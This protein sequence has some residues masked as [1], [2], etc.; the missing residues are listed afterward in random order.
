MDPQRMVSR[1][2]FVGPREHK[3]LAR[4][5]VRMAVLICVRFAWDLIGMTIARTDLP[6]AGAASG[7]LRT[8]RRLR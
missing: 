4:N 1:F 5:R 6:R 2:V 8:K 7:E 3:V